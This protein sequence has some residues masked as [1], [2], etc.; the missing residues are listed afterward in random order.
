MRKRQGMRLISMILSKVNNIYICIH[1]SLFLCYYF[2][3]IHSFFIE[4]DKVKK[5][6]MKSIYDILS[7]PGDKENILEMAKL[8]LRES[9]ER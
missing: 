5:E 3:Y 4:T 1:N 7:M 8:R 6:R 9:K 2:I